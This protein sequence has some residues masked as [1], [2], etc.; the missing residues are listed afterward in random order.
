V[1]V[2][3]HSAHLG[4]LDVDWRTEAVNA[5]EVGIVVDFVLYRVD[6]VARIVS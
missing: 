4:A 3:I 6:L 1:V 2:G 5:V